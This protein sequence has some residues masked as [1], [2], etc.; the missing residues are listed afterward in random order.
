[1]PLNLTYSQLCCDLAWLQGFI[2]MFE[3]KKNIIEAEKKFDC[4]AT[5]GRGEIHSQ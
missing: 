3:K 5:V 1:M 2:T 4:S